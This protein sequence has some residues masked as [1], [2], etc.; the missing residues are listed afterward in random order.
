MVFTGIIYLEIFF[1]GYPENQIY[2]FGKHLIIIA[3]GNS[4]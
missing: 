4:Q 1:E 2:T 3:C